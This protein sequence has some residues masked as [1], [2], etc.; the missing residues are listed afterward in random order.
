MNKRQ[1]TIH[2]I[3]TES[4]LLEKKKKPSLGKR[5]ARGALGF[6]VNKI[7]LPVIYAGIDRET[8]YGMGGN[9][10]VVGEYSGP[11]SQKI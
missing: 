3:V 11:Q 1:E 10:P 6:A 5:L 2:R 7:A 8:V 4:L 9:A